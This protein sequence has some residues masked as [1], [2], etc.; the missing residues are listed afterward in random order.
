[1]FYF[2]VIHLCICLHVIVLHLGEDN[3]WHRYKLENDEIE[4]GPAEKDV[5][6]LVDEKLDMSQQWSLSA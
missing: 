6:E 4:S 3:A 5:G 2:F 1:M